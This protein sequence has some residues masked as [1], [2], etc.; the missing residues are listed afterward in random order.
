[1]VH[2]KGD[3]VVVE[4]ALHNRDAIGLPL[5]G[6]GIKVANGQCRLIKAS[7]IAIVVIDRDCD[8]LLEGEVFNQ[9][10]VVEG[11]QVKDLIAKLEAA[12]RGRWQRTQIGIG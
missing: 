7:D 6:R 12:R 1:M 2:G 9:C 5:I 3:T 4:I 10:I 8:R 11:I